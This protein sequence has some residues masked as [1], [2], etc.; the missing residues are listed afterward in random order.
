MH[1]KHQERPGEFLQSY[2]EDSLNGGWE[3]RM[4]RGGETKGIWQ[5]FGVG[6]MRK[7]KEPCGISC[8]LAGWMFS[9]C[10]LHQ[11]WDERGNKSSGQK[12]EKNTV[13]SFWDFNGKGLWDIPISNRCEPT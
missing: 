10:H 3:E 11:C 5:A 7:E 9:M 13:F 6:I 8:Q 4:S 12:R 1:P 2:L